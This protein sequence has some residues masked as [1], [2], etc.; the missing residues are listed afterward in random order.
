MKLTYDEIEAMDAAQLRVAVAE[1]QG[2]TNVCMDEY[3]L[4]GVAAVEE[5]R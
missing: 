5:R 1:A 4:Q 3:G 2:F